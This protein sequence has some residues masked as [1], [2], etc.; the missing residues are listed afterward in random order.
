MRF[1]S[2]NWDEETDWFEMITQFSTRHVRKTH[3]EVWKLFFQ[4][5]KLNSYPEF[6][7]KLSTCSPKESYFLVNKLIAKYT[8]LANTSAIS[9]T[10]AQRVKKRGLFPFFF[11]FFPLSLL[12]FAYFF[13]SNHLK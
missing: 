6:L 4:E 3:G 11:F 8:Q 2:D 12:L 5:L 10:S 9:R 1:M 13:C 7:E